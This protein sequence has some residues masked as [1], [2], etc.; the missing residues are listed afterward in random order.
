MI[1]WQHDREAEI[2]S[3]WI[4]GEIECGVRTWSK[5]G[6]H[7]GR[8]HFKEEDGWRVPPQQI[9]DEVTNLLMSHSLIVEVIVI[10]SKLK[11]Y[12]A[13]GASDV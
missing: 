6:W 7:V 4:A 13:G 3:E 9:A 5:G 1:D 12:A 2:V 8:D 11:T 10:L